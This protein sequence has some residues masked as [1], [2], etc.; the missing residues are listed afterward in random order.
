MF[1]SSPSFEAPSSAYFSHHKETTSNAR[2]RRTPR[3]LYNSLALDDVVAQV[4]GCGSDSE[5]E[6]GTKGAAPADAGSDSSLTS[7]EELEAKEHDSDSSE[8]GAAVQNAEEPNLNIEL[9]ESEESS[10]EAGYEDSEGSLEYSEFE[11]SAV[12]ES[13]SGSEWSE[14]ES[15]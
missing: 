5:A 13:D 15:E 6:A 10:E 7:L 9:S 14:P 3:R 2:A 12:E 8:D 1:S 11:E 4:F